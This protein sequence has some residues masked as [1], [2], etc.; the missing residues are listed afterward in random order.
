MTVLD[1]RVVREP[2]DIAEAQRLRW[3]VY[4]EEE[5]LL[6]RSAGSCGR[7]IDPRDD[8]PGTIHLLVR[9]GGEPAGTIRLLAA[10]PAEDE[11]RAP[12]LGL[13]VE[14]TFALSLPARRIVA[15]E[16]TR[17]CV[18]RRYRGTGVAAA[19]FREL[20]AESRRRGITHWFAG[21]NMQSDHPEEAQLAY[22]L[23]RAR[24]WLDGE[25]RARPRWACPTQTLRRHRCYSEAEW[26]RAERGQLAGL[27]IP[28]TVAL[29]ALGMGARYLGRP[30]YDRRHGV[31]SLPLVCRVKQA[32]EPGPGSFSVTGRGH[33]HDE[34]G[35]A[36]GRERR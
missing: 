18:L 21:A 1:C 5:G 2:G 28:R 23:V 11:G 36:D 26:R 10:L 6:P 24:G 31:F 22:R 14:A 34:S 29:F 19:L 12:R 17:Y 4:G 30:A 15:A 20:R 33:H 7:D 27:P 3:Q 32:P 35:L 25:F 9:A 16:V 8:D 13:P